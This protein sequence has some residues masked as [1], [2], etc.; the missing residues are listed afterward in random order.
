MSLDTAN[1]R[2]VNTREKDQKR[3]AVLADEGVRMAMADERGR[4][5]LAELVRESQCL[6][7]VVA[8]TEQGAMF[9]EGR[10][11]LGKKIMADVQRICPA[12]F[13]VLIQA[14][15]TPPKAKIEIKS[16][17]EDDGPDPDS[18]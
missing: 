4:A 1:R 8:A 3:V 10:A 5:Y 11:V 13:P 15:V 17:K 14:V 6:A 12:Q 2:Q 16:E 18:E 9:R 7:S